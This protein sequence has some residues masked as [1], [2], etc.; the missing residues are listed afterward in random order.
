MYA[1]GI[2]L[3]HNH[4]S[5]EPQ[6]SSEDKDMT[7]RLRLSGELVGVR[8]VDHIIV[9]DEGKFFSFKENNLL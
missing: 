5:G 1:T 9:G 4:P 6:P 3:F 8:M 2:F 7:T